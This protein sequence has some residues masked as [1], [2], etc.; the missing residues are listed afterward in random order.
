MEIIYANLN[1]LNTR[2]D[3]RDDIEEQ[4]NYISAVGPSKNNG[5]VN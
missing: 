4:C 1:V 5:W 3:G 2:R